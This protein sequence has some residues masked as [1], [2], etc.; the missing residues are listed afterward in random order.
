[1]A[2]DAGRYAA[3]VFADTP[4]RFFPDTPPRYE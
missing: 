4:P 3:H 1:M 2:Y